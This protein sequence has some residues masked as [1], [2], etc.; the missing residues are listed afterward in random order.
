MAQN[1]TGIEFGKSEHDTICGMSKATSTSAVCILLGQ[2][3]GQQV[4][5]RKVGHKSRRTPVVPEMARATQGA[6]RAQC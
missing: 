4:V 6:W 5:D 2:R 1:A 3:R